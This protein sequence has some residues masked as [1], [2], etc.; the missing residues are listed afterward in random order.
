MTRT[1]KTPKAP[2]T[3]LTKKHWFGYMFGDWGG[4]M[5][6][7]LVGTCFNLYCTNALG[8]DPSAHTFHTD[9]LSS[10]YISSIFETSAPILRF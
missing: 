4:C 7:T 8:I 9:R 10:Y 6:F 5:T 1:P 3:G 2:K